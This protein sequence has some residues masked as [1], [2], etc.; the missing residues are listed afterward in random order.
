[1][2]LPLMVGGTEGD[3]V[4]PELPITL[5]DPAA[6]TLSKR[7]GVVPH[8]LR[9]LLESLFGVAQGNRQDRT[10]R[11]EIYLREMVNWL[12]PRGWQRNRDLPKLRAGLLALRDLRV[13]YDGW[14]WFLVD[15]NRLPTATSRLDETFYIDVRHLPDSDHGPLLKRLILRMYGDSP[16]KWRAFLRLA[17]IWDRAKM[18]NGGNPIYATRPAVERGEGGVLLDLYDRPVF[19]KNGLPETNWTDPRAVRIRDPKGGFATERHPQADRVPML[20][21]RDLIRLCYDDNPNLPSQ[22]QRQRLRTAR[23]KLREMAKD[24]TIVIEEEDQGGRGG[25]RIL[26]PWVEKTAKAGKLAQAA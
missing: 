15:I 2:E 14:E 20:P 12:W 5:H 25:M 19:D 7:G 9:L 18:K 13:F 23:Q 17:Y 8:E 6:G 4:V 26:E 3:S 21:P 24:G 11:L 22:A 16:P 1:M 10:V